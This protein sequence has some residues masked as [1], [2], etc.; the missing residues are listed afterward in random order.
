MREGSVPRLR[1]RALVALKWC[2]LPVR[3]A[4]QQQHPRLQVSIDSDGLH[5]PNCA[6]KMQAMSVESS[7]RGQIDIDVCVP[8]FV[9]W[10]DHAESAQLAPSAVVELFKIVN[11]SSD[12]PRLPLARALPC[13]RCKSTLSL[14]H[15]IC[16]AGRISYYRCPSHGRLTPFYQFLKEKHF[17]RQLSQREIG[18]LR[19]DVKQIK[20]SGCGGAIDLEQD[21]ACAYCGSAIAV[22]DADAVT[23][24]MEIWAA[25]AERRCN[26]SPAEISEAALRIAAASET[27]AHKHERSLP[28]ALFG[29]GGNADLVSACIATLGG[30]FALFDRR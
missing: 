23:K 5:C 14:T 6:E 21:T 2:G 13:P 11:I 10:L 15:D 29:N 4:I 30:L 22:L 25:A 17:I 28:D 16:K 26:S 24:A 1:N 27:L 19:V 18:Q 7:L 20:C 9:I 3:L 8:C 12:K